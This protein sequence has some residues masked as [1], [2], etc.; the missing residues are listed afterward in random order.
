M[1]AVT[2]FRTDNKDCQNAHRCWHV[3]CSDLFLMV[4][5]MLTNLILS[6]LISESGEREDGKKGYQ[7]LMRKL[8]VCFIFSLHC[9]FFLL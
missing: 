6:T 2:M 9:Q 4:Y 7:S 5:D 3:V 8:K 1:L